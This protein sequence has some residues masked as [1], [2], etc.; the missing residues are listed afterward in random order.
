MKAAAGIFA[1]SKARVAYSGLQC[2]AFPPSSRYLF[3]EKPLNLDKIGLG[4][5][6]TANSPVK[7][8]ASHLHS[9]D[10]TGSNHE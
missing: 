1:H 3:R 6:F 4:D 7:P 5:A 2:A 10:K 9:H 8:T